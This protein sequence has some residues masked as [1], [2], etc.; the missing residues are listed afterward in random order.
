MREVD[1][2]SKEF[3]YYV[4]KLTFF[5]LEQTYDFT[6]GCANQKEA[7]SQFVNYFTD[8]RQEISNA[9]KNLNPDFLPIK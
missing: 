4:D 2:N 5:Y 3:Q 7:T 8:R 6:Q 9:L 1:E